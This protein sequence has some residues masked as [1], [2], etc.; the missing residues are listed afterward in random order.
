[1]SRDRSSSSCSKVLGV[2]GDIMVAGVL[3]LWALCNLKAAQI[4]VKLELMLYVF[5]QPTK[6]KKKIRCANRLRNFVCCART[7]TIR[8]SP[9]DLKLLILRPCSK[10]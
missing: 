9:V 3:T 10:Q 5:E 7:S 1:M 4:N 2:F 6:K 8:Q